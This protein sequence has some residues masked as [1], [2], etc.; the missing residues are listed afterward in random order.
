M[1]YLAFL[2]VAVS[3]AACAAKVPPTF[4]R[5]APGWKTIELHQTYT[6]D[7]DLAWQKM[8]DAVA[9]NWDVEIMDKSS[10]YLRTTWSY[11]IGGADAQLYRGRLT[12]KFPNTQRP[13]NLELRTNAQWLQNRKRLLWVDGF[14]STFERDVYSELSGRLGRTV[15]TE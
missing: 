10:G 7:Y 3:I 13:T 9:R 8:V 11:G 14:D 2:F 1:R 4:V 5:Q 6:A 15:P 12:L